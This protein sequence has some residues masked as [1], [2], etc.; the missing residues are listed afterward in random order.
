[1]QVIQVIMRNGNG[2]ELSFRRNEAGDLLSA[3]REPD[4][5]WGPF[6]PVARTISSKDISELDATFSDK[7][8]DQ[9]NATQARY[10]FAALQA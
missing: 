4:G 8:K 3:S 10:I 7:T 9:M 1:M 5:T 6:G 2:L